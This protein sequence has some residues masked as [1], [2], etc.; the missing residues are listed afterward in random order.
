MRVA[1]DVPVM[2]Q[3]L[4]FVPVVPLSSSALPSPGAPVSGLLLE[5]SYGLVLHRG[6]SG[7]LVEGPSQGSLVCSG[8]L[9]QATFEARAPGRTLGAFLL[10][11]RRWCR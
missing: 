5:L 3:P 9:V 4:S 8:L 7:R 11:L 10:D 2:F 1:C 6:P